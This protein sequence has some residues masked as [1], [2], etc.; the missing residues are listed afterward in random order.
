MN[1]QRPEYATTGRRRLIVCCDGTWNSADKGGSTNVVR[2]MRII[3]S[4]SDD[5]IPQIVD[6]HPGVGTG[7]WFDRLGG[8]SSGVG[9]SRNIRNA[10]AFL[11]NNYHA[12]AAGQP[13]T[14]EIFIFGFSRGAFTARALNALVGTIGILA[15]TD[16]GSFMEA[17]D[18]YRLPKAQRDPAHLDK[19]FPDRI[20]DVPV[21]CVGVWDTVGSLGV[22]PNTLL[23]N[24][25]PCARS[26][27]FQ[28]TELGAHV[29]YAFQGLAIDEKRR[30]FE[31]TLWSNAAPATP[32]QI[33]HQ[34]WFCGVHSDV[35]GGYPENGTSAI[36]LLWMAGL[37]HELLDLDPM[38][39]EKELDR[40]MPYGGAKLHNTFRG[41]MR[42]AG[43][44]HRPVGP[45]FGQSVHSSVLARI[46]AGDYD[47]NPAF[48]FDTLPVW[49]PTSFEQQYA[50]S[51][52]A[53]EPWLPALVGAPTGFCDS[54][55]RFLG[56][57]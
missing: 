12:V 40:S 28:N 50:W 47:V 53:P 13:Y 3:K 49:E 15:P 6:Y 29:E 21:R 22:P 20:K 16:M 57:G 35:G 52:A 4:Q 37:V 48:A 26:Y 5:G 44:Y 10:Y 8:G 24:W 18:W 1:D 19:R 46:A 39:I 33:I 27:E 55:A 51:A 7:N 9:V 11:V 56:G 2:M 32:Y 45:G 17:W 34:T 43:V 30:P 36:P 31:P 38:A 42:L 25:H 23:P 14:D 41:F 54:V